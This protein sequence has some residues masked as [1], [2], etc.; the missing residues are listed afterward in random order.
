MALIELNGIQSRDKV[1][2]PAQ[3]SPPTNNFRENQEI[4]QNLKVGQRLMHCPRC[5]GY[6]IVNVPRTGISCS[7][8]NL[9][10]TQFDTTPTKPFEPHNKES[11]GT[12]E[13]VVCSRSTC[14]FQFCA[15]CLTPPHGGSSC[16]YGIDD[17]SSASRNKIQ[18]SSKESNRNLRRLA[19]L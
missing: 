5:N 7:P 17:L 8:T 18:Y 2:R 15:N 6:G 16:P 11:C 12:F 19:R 10:D 14:A 9:C 4:V 13:I 3:N 1:V